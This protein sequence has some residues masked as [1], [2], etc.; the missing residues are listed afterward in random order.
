MDTII[1]TNYC[2]GQLDED[3][4]GIDSRASASI[5]R[6]NMAVGCKGAGVCLGGHK[7]CPDQYD[8]A[9]KVGGMFFFVLWVLA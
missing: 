6:Y 8:I 5:I 7:V 2:I 9:C 1:E 4:A 3:S